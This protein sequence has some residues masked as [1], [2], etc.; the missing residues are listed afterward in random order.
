VIINELV[1]G[2]Y[3]SLMHFINDNFDVFMTGSRMPAIWIYP[4]AT[5]LWI[6]FGGPGFLGEGFATFFLSLK[7]KTR[8]SIFAVGTTMFANFDGVLAGFYVSPTLRHYGR[9]HYYMP[10]PWYPAANG[11]ISTV[12]LKSLSPAEFAASWP[13]LPNLNGLIKPQYY[14]IVVVPKNFVLS[15]DITPTGIDPNY[16]SVIHYTADGQNYASNGSRMPGIWF[17]PGA[18]SLLIAFGGKDYLN[19]LST[20]PLPLNV[21]TRVVIEA[22][23]NQ[24][25]V[26]FNDVYEAYA[27]FPSERT[28]GT[29]HLFVSDP[30][31]PPAKA[32]LGNVRMV[33]SE[34]PR[35]TAV[36]N[37]TPLA[38]TYGGVV[39]IPAN[40][41]LTFEVTPKSIIGGWA[42]ILHYTKNGV[43]NAPISRMPAIFF[44]PGSTALLVQMGY[45]STYGSITTSALPLNV[46]TKV[47]IE[48]LG[49]QVTVYFNGVYAGLYVGT[50]P[51]SS[52][53]AVLLIS[54]PW[55]GKG[56]ATLANVRLRSITTPDIVRPS[57]TLERKLTPSYY[58]SVIVP[59]D[60]ELSFF[61][62]PL[63]TQPNYNSVLHYSKQAQDHSAEG[64]RM[65]GIWFNP[66]ESGLLLGFDCVASQ[67]IY[68][69]TPA[70]PLSVATLIKVR[71]VG[72]VITV[73]YNNA[74][75]AT[76]SCATTRVTGSAH[77]FVSDPWYT[78]ANALI[79]Y[80]KM[81]GV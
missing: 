17:N 42:N 34:V 79:K 1:A 58:G 45:E 43:D 33:A 51:R 63:G 24:V 25:V 6:V 5:N 12:A 81:V 76:S 18:T 40:F 75:V 66:N 54:D 32:I 46:K 59:T 10:D 30:W 62:T 50:T 78:P 27:G 7:C 23:G 60:Y 11:T 53:N 68:I 38:L 64:T 49:N 9:A 14:G 15:F 77:L 74:A 36:N 48:A 31:H 4:G 56:D 29:A 44:Y 47:T 13:L 37:E 19:Y 35:G 69:T 61:I 72:K 28:T 52:G 21:K 41:S 20:K 8:V 39:N 16:A 73:F 57:L 80:L 71:A 55:H 67:T 22:I 65:P 2:Q 70:L 3:G 26:F